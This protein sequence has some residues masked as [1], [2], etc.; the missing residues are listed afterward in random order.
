MRLTVPRTAGVALAVLVI[1]N[2]AATWFHDRFGAG[3]L[4]FAGGRNGA[5]PRP[6]GYT[7]QGAYDLLTAYGADGRRWHLILSLTGDVL[8]PAVTVLFGL[9]AFASLARRARVGRWV[10]ALPVLYVLAD[11]A[12]NAGIVTMLLGYPD[13][14]DAVATITNVLTS[15]KSAAVG[16]CVLAAAVLGVLAWLRRPSK[17][18]PSTP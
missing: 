4:D 16:A 15:L 14:L 10:L 11:Y 1:M 9:V 12:E 18:A 6:E 7:P 17:S 2:G 5:D 8:L 13:R 3:I